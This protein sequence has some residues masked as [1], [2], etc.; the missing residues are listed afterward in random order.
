MEMQWA[1]VTVYDNIMLA[2][3]LIIQTHQ[4]LVYKSR[5]G[6]INI[7]NNECEFDK[8]ILFDRC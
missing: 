7:K 2:C 5:Q 4:M 8:N 1:S 3:R 6:K